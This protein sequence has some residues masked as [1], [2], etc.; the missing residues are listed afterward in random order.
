MN[1]IISTTRNFILLLF[2][3][4]CSAATTPTAT[5]Q[6]STPVPVLP[7]VQAI[8]PAEAALPG[9]IVTLAG[10]HFGETPGKVMFGDQQGQI[11]GWDDRQIDVKVPADLVAGKTD[12]SVVVSGSNTAGEGVTTFPFTV[13]E[14]S[15]TSLGLRVAGVYLPAVADFDLDGD[16]DMFVPSNYSENGIDNAYFL[17]NGDATFSEVAL[18]EAGFPLLADSFTAA[19]ADFDQDGDADLYVVGSGQDLYALNNGDGTFSQQ[20]LA[21]VGLEMRPDQNG[22][23]KLGIAVADFDLDGSLDVFVNIGFAEQID[24]FYALNNGDGTFTAVDLADAGIP[25]GGDGKYVTGADLNGDGAPDL[26]IGHLDSALVYL[27]NDGDGTFTQQDLA[28][29]GIADVGAGS[30]QSVADFDLDG[31]LDLFLG[32]TEPADDFASLQYFA[33]NN[34]DG[35][36]SLQDLEELGLLD[37]PHQ[38]RGTVAADFNNDGYA[39]L[40]QFGMFAPDGIFAINNGDGT[41]RQVDMAA[42]GLSSDI[43]LGLPVAADFDGDGD[44]DIFNHAAFA[45]N[46]G[47]GNFVLY[48]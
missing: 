18:E 19:T 25:T 28:A 35:T 9:A 6:P 23:E 5:L 26:W 2:V 40:Y 38:F 30:Q 21:E 22:T 39:D 32:D 29:A 27:L 41:F 43:T 48:R 1:R 45:R 37:P 44:L 11:V 12:I 17:N 24:N 46:L 33:Q 10:E 16:L 31:D 13:L 14:P 42:I 15:L 7:I 20:N 4:G 3:A 8:Y 36:F 47:D 34:G